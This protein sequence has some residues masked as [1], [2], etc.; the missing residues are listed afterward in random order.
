MSTVFSSC[1]ILDVTDIEEGFSGNGVP[2][3][4]QYPSMSTERVGSDMRYYFVRSSMGYNGDACYLC[5]EKIHKDQEIYM[6]RLLGFFLS[7]LFVLIFFYLFNFT[8]GYY[9]LGLIIEIY[10]RIFTI[11]FYFVKIN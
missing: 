5:K 3:I 11:L 7:L 10:L 9:V 8:G 4:F 2:S 6:Y 1:R